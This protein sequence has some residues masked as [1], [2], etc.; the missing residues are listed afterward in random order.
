[1]G[2]VK[3]DDPARR[4]K[5]E[6]ATAACAIASIGSLVGLS[7]T[8]ILSRLPLWAATLIVVAEL[9]APAFVYFLMKRQR[10]DG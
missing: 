6:I 3:R 9:L 1:M 4:S 5:V 10:D 2:C 7:V 8:G